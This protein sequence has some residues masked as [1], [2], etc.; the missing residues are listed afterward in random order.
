[1][2]PEASPG[3]AE[4][5]WLLGSLLG[6]SMLVIALVLGLMFVYVIKYRATSP[7]DRGDVA[8]KTWRLETAWTAATLV[9]FFGLFIWGADLFV[10]IYTPHANA[11]TI[12]VVAKQWM[13]KVEY[14]GGGRE[15]NQVHVPVG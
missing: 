11:L 1:M 14:P 10:R 9:A 13:W 5:D 12:N 15:I 3:A 8:R 6:I 4:T 7:L 2:I